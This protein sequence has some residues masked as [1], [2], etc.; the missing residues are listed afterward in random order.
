MPDVQGHKKAANKLTNAA[1]VS[2]ASAMALTVDH[3]HPAKS[4]TDG[5]GP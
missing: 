1:L 4:A 3:L 2:A 5:G